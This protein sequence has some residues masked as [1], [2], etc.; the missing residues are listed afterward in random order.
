MRELL[1]SEITRMGQGFCVIGL[2]RHTNGFSS[3]RPVPWG[4]GP[5]IQFPYDRADR[6]TFDFDPLPVTSPHFEDRR[7]A[8]PRKLG[9]VTEVEL[10]QCLKQAEV[11]ASVT[12]LFGCCP[13]PGGSGVY[14][15]P[16]DAR[17]S[18]CGCEINAINFRFYTDMRIRVALALNSG[19][20][21]QDL[22]L[23]D[24]D[25][26]EFANVLKDQIG[27]RPGVPARLQDCFNSFIEKQIT[28]SLIRFARI[29]LSRQFCGRRCWLMLDSLFPLPRNEWLTKCK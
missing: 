3:V 18:I 7:A 26:N 12:G 19:D 11:A 24:R 21:L 5:W 29:G 16:D 4:G 14:V 13:Y 23:V 1:I 2:E 27:E 10:V 6:V 22:P 9:A 20:T 25:W 15:N 28:T 17:Q 8:H